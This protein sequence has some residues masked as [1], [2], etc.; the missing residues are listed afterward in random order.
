[1]S[2]K[3]RQGD[4]FRLLLEDDAKSY[5]LEMLVDDLHRDKKNTVNAFLAHFG[6]EDFIWGL[7]R[8]LASENAR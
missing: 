3:W 1:M 5:A 2:L 7:V 8:L 6:S 4:Y